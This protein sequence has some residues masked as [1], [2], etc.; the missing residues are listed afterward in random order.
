MNNNLFIS[1]N[2]CPGC[3]SS[4]VKTIFGPVGYDDPVIQGFLNTTLSGRV[5]WEYLKEYIKDT[6][7]SLLNCENCSL[8]WQNHVPD[9]RLLSVL[10]ED[11]SVYS[12][13]FTSDNWLKL[14]SS[15]HQKLTGEELS[16]SDTDKKSIFEQEKKSSSKKEQDMLNLSH[17]MFLIK[18]YF[19]T[20]DIKVLDFGMGN[21]HWCRLAAAHDFE[22]FGLEYS[23]EKAQWRVDGGF[24]TISEME[25]E[26]HLFDFINTEQV[27]E[28]LNEPLNVLKNLRDKLTN[29]GIVRISVPHG[30]QIERKINN[31]DAWVAKKSSNLSL[32]A[33]RPL[34]HVNC[35]NGKSLLLMAEESGLKPVNFS[36]NQELN[37]CIGLKD[38]LKFPLRKAF[39]YLKPSYSSVRYFAKQ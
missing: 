15:V 26:N 9:G 25:L 5:D 12:Q 8:V 2:D 32:H 13:N 37:T 27:F 39:H 23:L 1:R 4:R 33:V 18:N 14:Y 36:F 16:L 19:D 24:Q 20:S 21:G 31:K 35:F 3:S 29:R 17:Q 22:T 11:L 28:H 30:Y 34:R 10:Y 7:Y 38:A 6:E